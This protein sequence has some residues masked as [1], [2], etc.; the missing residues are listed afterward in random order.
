MSFRLSDLKTRVMP[1]VPD[2]DLGED[3]Q[4]DNDLF[5]TAY[6]IKTHAHDPYTPCLPCLQDVS[7]IGFHGFALVNRIRKLEGQLAEAQ[8]ALVRLGKPGA[9]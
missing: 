8:A 6:R 9:A 2:A 3:R 7:L 5:L 4:L 1:E